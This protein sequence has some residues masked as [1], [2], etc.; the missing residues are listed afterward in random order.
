MQTVQL[1]PEVSMSEVMMRFH[2]SP[3]T[4]VVRAFQPRT[5]GSTAPTWRIQFMGP[6]PDLSGLAHG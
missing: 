5:E 1:F 6:R 3:G 2:N 4:R